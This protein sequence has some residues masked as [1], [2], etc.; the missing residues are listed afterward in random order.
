MSSYT[1]DQIQIGQSASVTKTISEHDVYTFAGITGD[2]NSA[3]VNAPYAEGTFFKGRI[4]HG[5]LTASFISTVLGM[6]LPGTG[7]IFL[8]NTVN[9]LA[10]VHFND[11][12]TTTCEVIEK[13][14]K[15]RVKLKAT[16]TNQKG[17]VVLTGESLVSPP[18]TK[19]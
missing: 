3:H 7:T 13:L 18:K 1:Y 16:V 5:M 10:P 19:L 12:L 2:F 11:T 14:E 8:S 9:F 4:A 6:Y 15:N 17:E